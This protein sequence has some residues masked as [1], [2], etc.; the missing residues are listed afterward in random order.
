MLLTVSVTK[1]G[2][3]PLRCDVYFFGRPI[4][5]DF[6]VSR[7]PLFATLVGFMFG[8]V[9]LRFLK[10]FSPDKLSHAPNHGIFKTAPIIAVFSIVVRLGSRVKPF[11]N[12]VYRH[13]VLC[14]KS[15][16]LNQN[17]CERLGVLSCI[18]GQLRLNM[19]MA[20]ST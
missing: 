7:K 6:F 15:P 1:E 13:A 11:S 16:Q 4:F 20:E 3:R 12:L 19:T 18:G 9:L 8:W 5:L 17:G 10:S 2:S 14:T